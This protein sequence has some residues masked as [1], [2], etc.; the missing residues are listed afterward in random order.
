VT[1][2]QWKALMG[3][4]PSRFKGNSKLPV[5]SVSWLDAMDFCEK[6]SQKTGRNYRLPNEAE[7][8]YAC[9]AG[10]TAPYTFG[11]IIT[12]GLMHYEGCNP[13]VEDREKKKMVGSF[14]ANMFGLYNMHGNPWE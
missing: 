14:P 7:W 6:L 13:Q 3:S 1:Q 10:T 12:P 4:N 5:D 2:G 9:R 8:K 11:E